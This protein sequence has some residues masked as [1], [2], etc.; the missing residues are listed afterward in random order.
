MTGYGHADSGRLSPLIRAA[1]S[2]SCATASGDWPLAKRPL[3]NATA[4]NYRAR[5][6]LASLGHGG[7]TSTPVSPPQVAI[8]AVTISRDAGHPRATG[9]P[10]A[11]EPV[12]HLRT[13]VVD[14]CDAAISQASNADEIRSDLI[15][16]GQSFRFP[17]ALLAYLDAYFLPRLDPLHAASRSSSLAPVTWL[18]VRLHCGHGSHSQ[19]FLRSSW[20]AKVLFLARCAR[21]IQFA[22]VQILPT[23]NAR[24]PQNVPA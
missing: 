15:V 14:G 7:R 21:R 18:S 3:G 11:D 17:P 16:A 20:K 12:T 24:R 10:E 19:L 6:S 1:Q 2:K 13:P 9:I 22:M 4:M 8:I 5:P 23:L